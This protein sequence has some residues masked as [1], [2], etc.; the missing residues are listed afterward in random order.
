MKNTDLLTKHKAELEMELNCAMQK[1]RKGSK[2]LTK[3]LQDKDFES[4]KLLQ[5]KANIRH[6]YEELQKKCSVMEG[7]CTTLQNG[8]SM[9][10]Q[11]SLAAVKKRRAFKNMC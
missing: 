6:N 10:K 9:L 7:R 3:K 2:E 1:T 11:E 5:E 4:Q 8:Y